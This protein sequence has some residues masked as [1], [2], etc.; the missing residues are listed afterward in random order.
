MLCCSAHSSSLVAVVDA[1]AVGLE[2][3]SR[4]CE[5]CTFIEMDP[6]VARDSLT[7]NITTCGLTEKA[8]VLTLVCC[9]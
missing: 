9:C 6:A 3:L 5:Q 7:R 8:A 2:A 4:G 1:G